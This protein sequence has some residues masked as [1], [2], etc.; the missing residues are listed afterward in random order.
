MNFELPLIKLKV[1]GTMKSS[2]REEFKK[3]ESER[4]NGLCSQCTVSKGSLSRQPAVV[5]QT[6]LVGRLHCMFVSFSPLFSLLILP[7]LASLNM[8]KHS[9]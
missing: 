3:G 7:F 4:G 6:G 9:H 8:S 2:G 5:S 1:E